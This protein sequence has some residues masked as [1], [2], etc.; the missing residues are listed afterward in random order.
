[1][2]VQKR[3]PER[4]G[5]LRL[6]QS[7]L[8]RSHRIYGRHYKAAVCGYGT[9]HSI[10]PS[11]QSGD[12]TDGSACHV[13]QNAYRAEGG[14]RGQSFQGNDR[15]L[16]EGAEISLKVKPLV[17]ILVFGLLGVSVAAAFS[18]GTAFMSDMDSTELTVKS[19]KLNEGAT[20]EE[21]GALTD[22]VVERITKIPDVENVGAMTS[23]ST[24]SMLGGGS[25]ST[26]ATGIDAGDKRG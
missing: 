5:H 10:F 1:M 4:S 15:S 9:N 12:C 24:M 13:L 11:C 20:L 14:Q 8:L 2:K 3:W 16:Y 21:T 25:G 18:N 22:T 19:A 26:N 23:A 7:V 6:L 17:F